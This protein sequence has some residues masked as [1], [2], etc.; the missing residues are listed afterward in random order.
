MTVLGVD[1]EYNNGSSL[2]G[3]VKNNNSAIVQIVPAQPKTLS[4]LPARPAVNLAFHDLYYRIKEG[5]KNSKCVAYY[6]RKA[7]M[8]K[9]LFA[10]KYIQKASLN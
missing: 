7:I 9:T 5:R 4:H 10:S 6:E 1:E 8:R 2:L 3:N